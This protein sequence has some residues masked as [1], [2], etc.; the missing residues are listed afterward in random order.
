MS[1]ICGK[2]LQNPLKFIGNPSQI[3][4]KRSQI[5]KNTSFERFRRQIAPRS[6]PGGSC[7]RSGIRCG[8]LF[9]ACLVENGAPRDPLKSE[10]ASKTTPKNQYGDLVAS[11]ESPG[12]VKNR[13]LGLLENVLFFGCFFHGFRLHFGSLF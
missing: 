13:F 2:S 1:K 12:A 7:E 3:N 6:A 8:H 11:G 4:Q 9:G 10:G 5:E